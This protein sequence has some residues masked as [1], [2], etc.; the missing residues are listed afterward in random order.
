MNYKQFIQEKIWALGVIL[1]VLGI[2]TLNNFYFISN[3]AQNIF[4]GI[5][6]ILS[7]ITITILHKQYPIRVHHG[8]LTLLNFLFLYITYLN[9]LI[10][11]PLLLLYPLFRSK[12]SHWVF[13]F[14]SIISY[15]LLVIIMLLT[16]FERLVFT[17]KTAVREI[18]SP[19]N[20]YMIVVYLLD[21]GALGGAT[22]IKL[23]DK[24]CNIFKRERLI[25]VCRGEV[26]DVKWIDN[27]HIK[28]DRKTINITH[29]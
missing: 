12:K 21:E 3:L 5:Y 24:Y 27:N 13:K 26:N 1:L 11:L 10:A 2:L 6:I 28:I 29:R 16:L 19:N 8:Y 17:S 7:V 20:K 15:A 9:H 23:A 25:Y 18:D 14:S 4:Y 22:H